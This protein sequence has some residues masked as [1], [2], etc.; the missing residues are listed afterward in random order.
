MAPWVT[1]QKMSSWDAGKRAC[2]STDRLD[3]EGST[4]GRPWLQLEQRDIREGRRLRDPRH[5]A[6][7]LL[8]LLLRLTHYLVPGRLESRS[9]ASGIDECGIGASPQ[10][11]IEPVSRGLSVFFHAIIYFF[12][13]RLY[14]V[15]YCRYLGHP[16][17]KVYYTGSSK[18]AHYSV[19]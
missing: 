2:A 12:E 19:F 16:G 3:Y 4:R 9:D 15:S 7:S 5:R 18:Q 13:M 11:T 8:Q 17:G 10:K 14:L 6:L 1:L